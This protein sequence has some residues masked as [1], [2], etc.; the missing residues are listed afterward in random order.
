MVCAGMFQL[1]VP[2]DLGAL[3]WQILTFKMLWVLMDQM[4]PIEWA[5]YQMR[6]FGP[7][8]MVDF[9]QKSH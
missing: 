4:E 3:V 2:R 1:M 7:A 8:W 6:T 9:K 5:K